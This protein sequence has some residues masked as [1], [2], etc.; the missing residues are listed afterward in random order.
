MSKQEQT[1][2]VETATKTETP[3][4]L[5][6]KGDN[7]ITPVERD[8]FSQCDSADMKALIEADKDVSCMTN[9]LAYVIPGK[10]GVPDRVQINNA[11]YLLCAQLMAEE[12]QPLTYAK[13]PSCRL[14]KVTESEKSSWLWTAEVWLINKKTG[15][16]DWQR[17]SV[18]YLETYSGKYDKFGDRKALAM[19]KRNAIAKLIPQMFTLKMQTK[20]VK[21]KKTMTIGGSSNN[22]QQT[23]TD[24]KDSPLARLSA[25]EMCVCGDKTRLAGQPNPPD[26]PLRGWYNCVAC[27]KPNKPMKTGD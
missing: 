3:K 21:E 26:S 10:E 14:D 19:A 5:P 1:P 23:T 15:Q 25:S 2:K 13:E 16:E 8:I 22:N 17:V 20:A 18:P 6:V 12:K 11:G 24:D 27:G 9:V 7:A 4:D